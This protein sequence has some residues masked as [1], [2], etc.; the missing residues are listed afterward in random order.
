MGFDDSP[1]TWERLRDDIRAIFPG[2]RDVRFSHAWG[3]PVSA[4]LDMFP[5]I[6]YAGVKTSSTRWAVWHGVSTT[7]LNGQTI[8]DLVLE[9]DT[10]LTDVF[11]VNRKLIPFPP[12][13]WDTRWP[14][15]SPTSCVGRTA[16]SMSLAEAD[17]AA[18]LLAQPTRRLAGFVVDVASSWS[19]WLGL[20]RVVGVRSARLED[21]R[22]A[23]H[24]TADRR[25]AYRG[26]RVVERHGVNFSESRWRCS[27]VR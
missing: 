15:R 9:R 8:R 11:F 5:A 10:D 17:R 24:R 2:L 25:R 14:D 6:G 18:P 20:D 1:Q 12:G 21:T 16:A 27:S 22:D 19:R 4:T 3:G 13:G 26:D 23:D 7:H